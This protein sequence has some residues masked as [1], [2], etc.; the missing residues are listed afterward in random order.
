M[1][2][3]YLELVCDSKAAVE[4]SEWGWAHQPPVAKTVIE[5]PNLA[6]LSYILHKPIVV[7]TTQRFEFLNVTSKST[8]TTHD[9]ARP[10]RTT[11]DHK[12]FS[13]APLTNASSKCCRAR[14]HQT[15]IVYCLHGAS[16][17]SSIPRNRPQA[18]AFENKVLG[19]L[20]ARTLFFLN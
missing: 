14:G 9:H 1:I 7:I 19:R 16:S 5:L 18:I 12:S 8:A 4:H 13:I 2:S 20:F 17:T 10:C 6:H 3:A 11:Q 15:H